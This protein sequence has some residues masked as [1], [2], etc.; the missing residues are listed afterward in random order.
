MATKI[1]GAQ[2]KD[3]LAGA[4][5]IMTDGVMAVGSGTGI[6]VYDDYIETLPSEIDHDLL[7]N[8]VADEHIAH[9]SVS[10]ST[11]GILTG[12]G[13]IAQSRT[14][15]L[16]S[17]D[18]D[19][20]QTTNFVAAEHIRWDLTGA[21]DIHPDRIVASGIDH[22]GL[23]S[24]ADD[25]H[26]QYS[27]V[28]GARSFT[29]TVGGITP[30]DDAHLATKWYVDNGIATA[31]GTLISDHG[32]LIGLDDNDHT[33]YAMGVAGAPLSYASQT[34]T[35]N[36]D[37]I[38]LGVSGTDLYVKDSGIDH[39]QTTNYVADE[40]IAHSSVSITG[41]GILSGGG[42]ITSSRSI[43]LSH[44]GVDHDQT[45]NFVAAE[46]IR[47][48]LTGAEDIHPDRITSSGVTQYV[49]D[50]DHGSLSGL[51]DD[52]HTMYSRADG[53]RP[54]T[55]TVG[56]ITP[57]ATSDLTTKGYVDGLIQGL[58]WQ[59]SVLDRDLTAPPASG[60]NVGDRYIVGTSASG[61]WAGHDNEIAE[62]SGVS[63][64]FVT[65][66]GNEGT[67]TWVEDEDRL[68]VWN[69]TSWATFGSNIEHNNL[70][71]IQGGSSNEY[72]HL[73]ATDYDALVT[74]RRETIEDYVGA[75]VS[76][77]GS[78]QTNITVSYDDSGSAAGFLDFSVNTATDSVLGVASFS[79][80][81]FDVTSG[82][83]SLEDTVLKAINTESGALTISNHTVTI[84]GGEGIDVTHTGT[85]ISVAGEDASDT[86][87]GVASFNSDD[88]TVTAGSVVIATGG[89]DNVQLANSSLTVTAGTGM[90]GGGSVSLG[91]STT[92]NVGAGD[93]IDVSA[94]GVAVDYKVNDGLTIDATELTIAYDDSTIGII[95]NSLAV[96]DAGIT[97]AKLDIANSPS[98]GYYLKYTTASGMQWT[99]ITDDT[100]AVLE[101]DIKFED[102]SSNCDGATT[103]FTLGFTPIA[104]SVQVFLNGLLQQEG[105]G[106]DY[107]LSGTT[108]T[109]SMAPETSDLLL[110]YYIANN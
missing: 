40:H 30:T 64:D 65:T 4:G 32:E 20:D 99:N 6:R 51:S 91:G 70:I 95:S 56:G 59:D 88:F 42:D 24:L 67:A 110:I 87:K 94:S 15:S 8:Y 106:N 25:D 54:F 79:A 50:L 82:A 66:S 35:F 60:T 62:W 75:M 49:N 98:D 68:L 100:E 33:Q 7:L 14:I 103:E 58:D 9:S 22:G 23:A 90:I 53:T 80:S 73:S 43:S 19:H 27:L 109:F 28:D 5:L 61:I 89:V 96:K 29:S 102:E 31:T 3:A 86:N 38:D 2:I 104:N 1:R 16:S 69:G 47:W 85:T 107:E 17:S 46:H 12:G 72:Y 18:V 63:W 13:T 34:V 101:S 77:T 93:G 39:D 48:D 41:G 52:D 97:E 45:T 57:V 11:G 21:E 71:G 26:T 83:V 84:S 108:V 105:S 10:I 74:Y 44:S 78:S 92:L 81:D 37:S 36:Y 55:S 76:G